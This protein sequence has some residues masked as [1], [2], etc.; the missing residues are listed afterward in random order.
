MAHLGMPL[1]IFLNLPP[2]YLHPFEDRPRLI[3][4]GLQEHDGQ[5]TILISASHSQPF[6]RQFSQNSAPGC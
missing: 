1:L 6:N 5:D 2:P 3:P 4:G